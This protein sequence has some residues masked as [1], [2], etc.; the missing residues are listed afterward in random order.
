MLVLHYRYVGLCLYNSCSHHYK[1]SNYSLYPYPL[2]LVNQYSRFISTLVH[3]HVRGIVYQQGNYNYKELSC[4]CQQESLKSSQFNHCL[5]ALRSRPRHIFSI[6]K[7]SVY[8]HAKDLNVLFQLDSLSFNNK[9][10]CSALVYFASKVYN[11]CLLC[12]KGYP[13]SSLLV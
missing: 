10:L 3:P 7:P 8:N 13:T 2:D 4:C 5:Q 1:Y 12:F 11:Y 9:R 6:L